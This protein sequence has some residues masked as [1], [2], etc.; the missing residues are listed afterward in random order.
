MEIEEITC[1]NYTREQIIYLIQLSER[2]GRYEDMLTYF[3]ILITKYGVF[4]KNEKNLLEKPIKNFVQNKQKK[5]NKL[6]HLQKEAKKQEE[7]I[8]KIIIKFF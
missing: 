8:L 1:K 5:L 7:G 4:Y 6:Y 3:E 2:C